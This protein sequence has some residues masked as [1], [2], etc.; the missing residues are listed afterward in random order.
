MAQ[1]SSEKN[2]FKKEERLCSFK[3]I[4]ALKVSGNPLFVY[5]FRASWMET[6]SAVNKILI[7]APKRNFKKA[8]DRNLIRRRIRESYRLNKD[9]LPQR[10]IDIF[11]SYI[12]K[13]ILEY[14]LIEEKLK[15]VL[16]QIADG[17]AEK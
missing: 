15:E 1:K 17:A 3:E 8:V 7:L 12:A 13:E 9:I 14:N 11:V 10:G 4:E 2:T 16:K 6:G 5:P